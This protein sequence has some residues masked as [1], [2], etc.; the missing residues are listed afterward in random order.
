MDISVIL[1]NAGVLSAVQ[2][3]ININ[4]IT[5]DSRK[6]TKDCAFVCIEGKNFDGHSFAKRA[7][8]QGASVVIVQKDIGLKEQI[9]VEDTRKAYSIMCGNFCGNP[10]KK[11]KIIGVTGTNGKTTT[12]YVLKSILDSLGE[13]TGLMGTIK[14][15]VGDE[16]YPS[17][18]TTPDPLEF[19]TLL[20]EMVKKGCT[21]CVME[22][23]SQALAQQRVAGIRFLAGIFTNLTQDHL[24]YHGSFEEYR[25]AKKKLFE[26]TDLAVI[27]LDDDSA[28][29]MMED[30]DCRTVTY[31]VNM[32][33]SDYTAKYIQLKNTG[34]EYELVGNSIIGR[35]RFGVP[36]LFSV[37][38]SMGAA[39]CAVE[40]GYSFT[41]VL[42]ALA[43]TK[44]VPGRLEVVP[45]DT[46]YSVV[47]D[48]AHS[49]GGLENIL[50]ALNEI[51]KN[52]L[53]TVFGCGGDRDKA[54]RPIM[55]KIAAELSD[56]VVITSDN[57]RTEDPEQIVKE[58]EE[59]TQGIRNTILIEVDRTKAI[60][61]ALKKAKE[62]DIVLLAGKGHETYQIIKTGKIHYDEREIVR[63]ILSKTR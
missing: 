29:F 2:S 40:L 33:E 10:A 56:I 25:S 18:L 1:E 11:L 24:D 49:P 32:D 54:K 28:Q 30:L 41:K 36:G 38:N 9:I 23:S 12:C 17:H 48:Y 15:I 46:N 60:E 55:G 4:A 35:V 5:D 59:G 37:Y 51:K 31:S 62:N 20:K 58:V 27:N 34:A 39:V 47:I 63:D 61:L 22:V 21:Y 16:E 8:E 14:N 3:D 45:T 50:K 53:I 19:H 52:R 13:K 42:D 6:I 57:P 7:I 26:T 43:N 44:G